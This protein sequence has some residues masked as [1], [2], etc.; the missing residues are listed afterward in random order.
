MTCSRRV[1]RALMIRA[2]PGE[3][4]YRRV[5]PGLSARC[6]PRSLRRSRAAGDV[7]DVDGDRGRVQDRG[8]VGVAD[9][10]PAAGQDHDLVELAVLRRVVRRGARPRMST[11]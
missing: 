10:D 8:P 5:R 3:M 6:L 9:V 7:G 4:R 11:E 1:S 2:A